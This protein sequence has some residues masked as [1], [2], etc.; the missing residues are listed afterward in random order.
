MDHFIKALLL[1]YES[2]KATAIAELSVL[3][4]SPVGI[5]DHTN[6]IDEMDV[7]IHKIAEAEDCIE[8]VKQLNSPPPHP[9]PQP[10]E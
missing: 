10:K 3:L 1:K 2:Q 9:N 8:I 6:I 5:G 4:Q 7:K